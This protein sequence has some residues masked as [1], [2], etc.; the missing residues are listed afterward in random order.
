MKRIVEVVVVLLALAGNAVN[1][2]DSPTAV[3]A[4]QN[5]ASWLSLTD[6]G[7]YGASWEQASKSFKAAITDEKWQSAV[8]SAREPLG[9]VTERKVKSTTFANSLPGVPDGEYVV[10]QYETRFEHKASAIET[11]TESRDSDGSWKVVGYFIK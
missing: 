6:A 10:I 7:R 8:G 3:A 4:Q 9:K 5:A 11:L 2:Q 1:A